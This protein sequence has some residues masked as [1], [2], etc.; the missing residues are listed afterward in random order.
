MHFSRQSSSD[1]ETRLIGESL[2]RILRAG[3]VV[4]LDGPLGAGKTTLIRSVAAGLG[5]HS[6]AVASPTFVLIHDYPQPPGAPADRPDLI[7]IDAYRL[8]GPED[9]D[10]LGWDTVVER[11]APAAAAPSPH[12]HRSAALAIEW[13]ERLGPGLFPGPARITIDHVDEHTR[14]FSFDLPD[15][16][17]LRPGFA[18]LHN[19]GPATCPITGL[20]VPPD[21]PTYPFANERARMADL[22]RWFSG[23]YS[24]SRDATQADF[25]EPPPR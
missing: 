21:S 12:P 3:D 11:L 2:G 19:R 1:A 22:Y 13:A 8:R 9:L 7:H 14:E 17:S 15:D 10:S 25:D 23:G 24:V 5:L 16:W 4:Y 18:A 20:S 6:A